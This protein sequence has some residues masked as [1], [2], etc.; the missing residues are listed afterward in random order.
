M[1]VHFAR[2]ASSDDNDDTDRVMIDECIAPCLIIFSNSLYQKTALEWLSLDEAHRVEL[3]VQMN[4]LVRQLISQ[5]FR[6]V[7]PCTHSIAYLLSPRSSGTGFSDGLRFS[8][9]ILLLSACCCGC[10]FQEVSS[11]VFVVLATRSPNC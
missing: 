6:S 5:P 10:L 11:C 8:A 7:A 4:A 3:T 9:W 2:A 1:F